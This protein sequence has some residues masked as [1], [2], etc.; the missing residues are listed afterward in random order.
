M[1]KESN[2]RRAGRPKGSQP[3][4]PLVLAGDRTRAK[5]EIEMASATAR[6]L[7]EYVRWIELSVGMSTADAMAATAEFALRSVFKRDRLW[8]Q[9]QRGIAGGK[10]AVEAAPPVRSPVTQSLPPPV[11]SVTRPPKEQAI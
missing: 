11:S 10:P 3:T 1:E 5:I 7:A 4:G 6:E 9:H 2:K 8:Q